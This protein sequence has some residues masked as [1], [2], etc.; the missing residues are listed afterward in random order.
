MSRVNISKQ[1]PDVYQQVVALSKSAE[2]AAAAAGLDKKLIELVKIRVSQL[3]GCA[4]CCRLHTRDAV[5]AGET[6]DRL[7]VL[8]AWW[9]SQYFSEQEQDA[10]GLAE[11]VTRLSVPERTDW[12]NGSLNPEQVSAVSWLAVVM[13]SW[14]RVAIRSG[15]RVAP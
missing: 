10:L 15:Y 1:H 4:F 7:A 11:E 6:A 13:N 9:E 14:N 3:N 12:D 8:P 2:E 5:S